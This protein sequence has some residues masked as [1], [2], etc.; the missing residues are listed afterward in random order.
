MEDNMEDNSWKITLMEDNTHWKI[1]LMKEGLIVTDR[2]LTKPY[3]APDLG[4]SE[5][6]LIIISKYFESS[7]T[8]LV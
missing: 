3:I 2:R 8:S 4:I 1:T 7:K 5:A 6:H